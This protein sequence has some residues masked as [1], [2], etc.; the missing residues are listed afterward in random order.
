MEEFILEFKAEANGI[1][2]R[3]QEQLLLLESEKKNK[4]V[5][6]EIFRAIH[7]LKGS[8]RMFGFENIEKIT[9]DLENTF[10]LIRNDKLSASTQV[11]ELSLQVVD[12]CQSILDGKDYQKAYDE[13]I[14]KLGSGEVHKEETAPGNAAVYQVLYHPAQ[15][16][17]ER[18][19]NP[20][21]V[22]NELKSAGEY[23]CIDLNFSAP[24]LDE[25]KAARKFESIF[26]VL[27]A[28]PGRREE[29]DDIFIFLENNEFTINEVPS[30]PSSWKNVIASAEKLASA[31]FDESIIAQHTDFLLQQTEKFST[32][33]TTGEETPP[34]EVK[35]TTASSE[36]SGMHYINVKLDRLDNMMRLVSELVT[37]KA[38][39]QYRASVLNNAE[40]FNAVERLEK[41]TTRFRD[42]AFDM[43]LVPLQVLSMKFQRMVRDLGS[44]LGKEINLMT[45]GLDTEIDKTIINE[46]EAPLMHII[47]NAI[48]HGLESADERTNC[49]KD[50]KGMLKIVA[51][52]A[53]ANVFIQI[54]DDGRGLNLKR[55]REKA[56]SK[57]I[58]SE[59]TN[60]TDREIIDLIFVPGFSTHETA[61]E[62][63]GRGVGMDVVRHKLKE[64]RGSIEITTEEGL[65]TAFT[66]RLPLSLSILD[67]LHVKVNNV[68]Y[69]LPHS[70]VE[71]CL[72]ERLNADIIQRRGHN[73]QYKGALIPHLHLNSLVD[74]AAKEQTE[75]SSIVVLSKNDQLVSLEVDTIVGEEQLVIKPVDEALKDI[76]FLSGVAVLGNGELAF[77]VDSLKLKENLALGHGKTLRN[78]S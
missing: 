49:G 33:T 48:D 58:I 54:Q 70:E 42:N 43:R 37:I 10:D 21:A 12:V 8:S 47:R 53:G 62:Y 31:S 22:I 29:F 9:H 44:K 24:S 41:V 15:N 57:G 67:V 65:G 27:I 26:E 1:L 39:L 18:G 77:L 61:T 17:Y 59:N 7:T 11:V 64:L 66:I 35:T 6:E 51:F 19:I 50:E 52:Y 76:T 60:L 30:D 4:S 38:E 71:S 46:I 55:I 16:I 36:T 73:V 3:L 63:S 32:T 20:M 75:E 69:L 40:L 23:L 28:F 72:S 56:I 25:Q 13:I 14:A 45:D 5:I 78:A 74:T 34:A 68:N 2:E